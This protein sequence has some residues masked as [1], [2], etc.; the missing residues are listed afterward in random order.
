MNTKS[1][2]SSRAS[3]TAALIVVVPIILLSGTT[4][5]QP[6]P[7]FDSWLDELRK[8][9]LGLGIA[10][11]SVDLAF[12]E[13]TPPV[14]RILENDR[15]Q[16]ETI[17]SYVSYLNARVSDWR[18]T[19]GR[20]RMARHEGL[21]D[22]IANLY[23]V[24]ARFIVA[25]WG[26]ETNFGTYPITESVFNV[27]ATLAFDNRRAAFFRAQFIAAIT[28][29]DSGF[30]SY[31]NM[32]SSWAGAMGQSQFI[33]ES[34]LQYA[35]DHN[36]DGRKDIWDTED[37]VF[38]SIANYFKAHG[39]KDDQTWGRPV[40]LP[41]N[42]EAL[43]A[44]SQDEGLSPVQHCRRYRSLGIW[45]DL[46]EW[47]ALGVRR[48]DGSDLPKRSISA[49]L[50]MADSGDNEAYVVYSNFCSIMS[51]NPALKY[52]LSIG[53]LSDYLNAD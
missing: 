26:M 41:V 39:W 40:L 3:K 48:S 1:A 4:Y 6:E 28:M 51:Y 42:D 29:L 27:L 15:S 43:L 46:Q 17:Q 7:A 31:E 18:I 9:V 53:L 30:P 38:A 21:L 37:D 52:A 25:I 35:V 47:Q 36:G 32:K 33:P 20:E 34:Y 23:S 19:N 11:Q 22:E 14:Q 49:A 13:I 50:I 10:P 24:Q 45:R 5:A 12:S 44:V 2:N 8:E 16:P